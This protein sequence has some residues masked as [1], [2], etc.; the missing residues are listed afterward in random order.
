MEVPTDEIARMFHTK[1]DPS[2]RI[3][4]PA[5]LRSRNQIEIGDPMVVVEHD[6]GFEIKTL[7]Q[8]VREAQEFFL[9]V[10]PA[11]VSLVDELIAERKEEA[12][13]E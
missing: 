3:L 10:I 4:L 11:D 13:R 7:E 5:E 2:G 12:L 8:S 1:V 6:H 9:S